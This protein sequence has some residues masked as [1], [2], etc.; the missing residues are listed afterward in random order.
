ME[1]SNLDEWEKRFVAWYK[2]QGRLTDGSHDLGHFQRVWR[3]AREITARNM[4]R[5]TRSFYWPRPT[6]MTWCHCR[7]TIPTGRTP[8][9]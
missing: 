6:F 8:R 3:L 1:N 9:G 2:S 5:L 4:S 7:R